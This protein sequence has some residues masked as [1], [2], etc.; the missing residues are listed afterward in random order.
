MARRETCSRDKACE[1]AEVVGRNRANK[2][3]S[4][5]AGLIGHIEQWHS[6]RASYLL[7]HHWIDEC[8]TVNIGAVT[9]SRKEMIHDP[10]CAVGERQFQFIAM[11]TRFGHLRTGR[12]RYMSFDTISQ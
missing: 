2:E 7:A 1:R 6:P 11:R 5:H 8:E 3:Q 9:C 10:C 4:R 12:N